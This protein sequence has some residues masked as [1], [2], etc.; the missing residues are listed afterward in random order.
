MHR[1]FGVPSRPISIPNR[2]TH[3]TPHGV[4]DA[5]ADQNPDGITHGV[6]YTVPDAGAD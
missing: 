1:H 4:P 2:V 5:G 6:P 3:G